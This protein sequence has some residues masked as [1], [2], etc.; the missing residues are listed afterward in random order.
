MNFRVKF[1]RA[2]SA[3]F[4]GTLL[5][6]ALLGAGC[7]RS[8]GSRPYNVVLVSFDTTRADHLGAYGHTEIK[9]PAVD[10]LAE[11]GV[12]F[13]RAF[14]PVPITLPSHSTMMT[15][16]VPFAHGVRDNGL[17]NLG[18]EQETLAEIL[19]DAGYRTAA[20]IGA[21]PLI[22]SMGISQGFELYDDHLTTP[23]E[24]LYGDRIFPKE[25]LFFD[26]RRAARVNEAV[27]PWLEK[28]HAE[29][30]FLWVH[31]FDPHEPHEPPAPFGQIYSHELY[32][33]EIAYADESLGTLLGHLERLGV[34]DNTLIV[35]TSDH[36]EGRGE[37]NETTHSMLVYNST[38]HVPLIMKPPAGVVEPERAGARVAPKVS[39]TDILPT[40]LDLL[41]LETPEKIQ[42]MSLLPYLEGEGPSDAR[43]EIYAETLSP[44]LSRSWGEQRALFLG[45]YKYIHG[46]RS[47]LYDITQDPR[48]VDNLIDSEAD[49]AGKM[50]RKLAS[51]LVEHAVSGLDAS[52]AIDEETARRLQAL[53][54]LQSSGS[55]LGPIE[56]KLS[57]EGDAPQDHVR[58][59]TAYSQAKNFLF[60]GRLAEGKAALLDLLEDD[61]GNP[62]Y[63]ELLF[64][65]ELRLG[66]AGEALRIVRR[67]EAA[68]AAYP[69]REQLL[70][71]SAQVLLSQGQLQ[72]GLEKLQASQEIEATASGQFRIAKIHERLGEPQLDRAHLEKALELDSGFAP[73]RIDLGI[74]FARA[75][76]A[77][78]ARRQLRRAIEDDPYQ[79]RGLFN[80][81]ALLVQS[82]Q[83]SEALTYFQRAV[84]LNGRY[85]EAHYA[86]VET[87][88]RLGEVDQALDAFEVM[89]SALPR[90][91]ATRLALDL[92]EGRS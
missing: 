73:A 49:L 21:F 18:G 54:Y 16:K 81:G 45:D 89:R 77:E 64:T 7:Q 43:R 50:E 31:Y 92:L 27:L 53:G 9:T 20:A 13:E 48:E 41:G 23:Y 8:S 28:H 33:G 37:H 57:R 63:L 32:D 56:E 75:G 34:Y 22:G 62:H 67:L 35:M 2:A 79:P 68:N 17:F 88:Y 69:P 78:E 91:Q 25:R 55:G 71:W 87:H 83:L 52:V 24:D 74:S 30:F 6:G 65:A 42:G 19:R 14:S 46:P 29:P 82:D 85:P 5:F 76:D 90:S 66:R 11:R 72:Q 10:G 51:Y 47:E 80:Y 3:L 36:G 59:I 44:R 60:S 38:L 26:E 15:G 70:D 86:L 12:L 40:V 61:P 39:T 4:A 58:T 1:L 84:D